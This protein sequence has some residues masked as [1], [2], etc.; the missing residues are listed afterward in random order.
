[1][2]EL[3]MDRATEVVSPPD[4]GQSGMTL[5]VVGHGTPRHSGSGDTTFSVVRRLQGESRFAHVVAAFLDQEPTLTRVLESE[6]DGEAVV[7]PF[8][9]SEGWH[10]GTTI[11]RDLALDGGPT[12][13]GGR[14][15]WFT[16][17]V[18][19]HPAMTE[20]IRDLVE[21]EAEGAPVGA[22]RFGKRDRSAATATEAKGAFLAWIRS[23][24]E[25]HR[26]FLQTVVWE[27]Q[28]GGFE[29][30]H[31]LDRQAPL[32][33]L[34]RLR[35]PDEAQSIAAATEA[36]D[37]RPL[38]TAPDLRGGWRFAGLT[39]DEAWEVYAH[40]YPAVPVHWF[41]ERIGRL[42][43]VSFDDVAKRQ[44]GIHAKVGSLGPPEVG[45]LVEECCESHRC[46]REPTWW[47][48]GSRDELQPRIPCPAACS[49]F[50]SRAA[51]GLDH[52]QGSR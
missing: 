48:K 31:E 49:V 9:V 27:A 4:G 40:L 41:L 50:L 8:F 13:T 51:S 38:K 26:V 7:V 3:V 37:Y 10:V 23:A 33:A 36:G 2:A 24:P 28:S 52:S 34:R 32:E 46:L 30:R 45:A 17:P 1:M 21:R 19:T 22:E 11:P 39:K 5:V 44:T 25:G 42:P 14:R 15:I 18:G 29:I 6:I 20:V 35:D 47:S 12:E 43:V 16:E